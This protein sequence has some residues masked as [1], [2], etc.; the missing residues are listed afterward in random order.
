MTGV[1]AANV[2]QVNYLTVVEELRRKYLAMEANEEDLIAFQREV[3]NNRRGVE[4]GIFDQSHAISNMRNAYTTYVQR[5]KKM[6]FS[7]ARDPFSEKDK[8][9]S[10]RDIQV[11][12]GKRMV[13]I[14]I[15]LDDNNYF[16]LS[17][18]PLNQDRKGG[19]KTVNNIINESSFPG[20]TLQHMRET[21]TENTLVPDGKGGQRKL[22][23]VSGGI[24]TLADLHLTARYIQWSRVFRRFPAD[25]TDLESWSKNMHGQIKLVDYFEPEVTN[26]GLFFADSRYCMYRDRYNIT[27][28]S[29]QDPSRCHF[30][31]V[32]KYKLDNEGGSA[33][34]CRPKNGNKKNNFG[35]EMSVFATGKFS[36]PFLP[37]KSLNSSLSFQTSWWSRSTWLSP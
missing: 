20:W 30:I 31:T 21:Q 15:K 6:D 2:P 32:S 12:N 14:R 29:R 23:G 4:S 9:I 25:K 16:G 24:K 18:I 22:F 11:S 1:S 7:N 33:G 10:V 13:E 26:D 5:N 3:E 37:P 8:G 34:G 19:F 35:H 17:Y 27:T 28:N 36:S